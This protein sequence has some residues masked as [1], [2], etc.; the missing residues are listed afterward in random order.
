MIKCDFFYLFIKTPHNSQI[1]I[2]YIALYT[3]EI[4]SKQLHSAK[5]KS[6]AVFILK[7]RFIEQFEFASAI[8]QL[9]CTCTIHFSSAQIVSQ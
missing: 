9:C 3:V 1:G 4:A 6:D 5:K 8:K 7:I 2:I